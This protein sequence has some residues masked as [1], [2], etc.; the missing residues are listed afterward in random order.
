MRRTLVNAYARVASVCALLLASAHA[1]HA[2]ADTTRRPVRAPGDSTTVQ[3]AIYNRPFMASVGRTAIGG[4]AEGNTNWFVD[5]GVGDGFS[6]EFRRFNIFLF[7]PVGPR[8]RFFAELEFEHGTEE[9]ALETAQLDWQLT[10][11]VALRGGIILPSLGA[12]NQNHDS[13]RWEFIDRPLVSTRIIPAT[14]SEVGF[15][16]YGRVR[17][18]ARLGLTWDVYLT[19]G[20]GDGVIGNAEGRT[21][22]AAGK[23]GAA[24][25]EDNNGSPA[26]S[27]R[28]AMQHAQFGEFGVSYYGGVYNRTHDAGVAVDDARRVDVV[29]FDAGTSIG[30]VSIR[31][32]AAMTSIDVPPSLVELFGS[33][34]RGA[35]VDIVAPVLR[36]AMLGQRNAILNVGVRLE[37]VDFNVGRFRSTGRAIGDQVSAIVPGISLRPTSTTVFKANYRWERIV[38]FAGNEPAKRAGVQVGFATYF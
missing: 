20:L 34:Q 38:D 31:G 11:S 10:P 23:G 16:A 1:L 27:G 35:H 13:P 33:R 30:I 12:F 19:N 21:S 37:H 14:L 4:Y 3:G 2:Q 18:T 28:V 22:L 24:F 29:A 26:L 15:G 17:P 8:L 7:S 25:A 36:R 5:E 6:M 9:I 32:E